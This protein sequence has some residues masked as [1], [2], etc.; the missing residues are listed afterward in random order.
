MCSDLDDVDDVIDVTHCRRTRI[1]TLSRA[2]LTMFASSS[3]AAFAP[4]LSPTSSRTSS[5]A[6]RPAHRAVRVRAGPFD[7]I[8]KAIADNKAVLAERES[9]KRAS[10]PGVPPPPIVPEITPATFGFVDNAERMNSRASMVGWWA[11]L[12]VE[13]VAG[14]G[15]LEIFGFT[16]GK[17]INFTF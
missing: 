10:P 5:R 12:L 15:L 11:L 6:S 4:K 13:G 1:R 14:K 7:G 3:R 16:V 9:A 2:S 17:G 8:Q